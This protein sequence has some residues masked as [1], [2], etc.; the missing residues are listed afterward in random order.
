[1]GVAN[2]PCLLFGALGNS[3]QKIQD[4]FRCNAINNFF[5]EFLAEFAKNRLVSR[6]RIFFVNWT[7]GNPAKVLQLV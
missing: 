3:V 1:V 6:N 7:C 5:T 4:L 2:T